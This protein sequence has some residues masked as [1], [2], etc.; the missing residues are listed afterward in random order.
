VEQRNAGVGFVPF[1]S[2][3]KLQERLACADIHVV[4]L[5]SDWTGMVVPSKFFGAL[6]AGRPVLFVGGADSSLARW[7]EEFEIG[8]VL[9][10]ENL[11]QVS[12]QLLSYMESTENIAA[13]HQRCFTVYQ[14]FFSRATQIQKFDRSLRSL[15]SL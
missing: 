8:W 4:T 14:Q 6:A 12:E 15:L 1:A 3:E 5:R 2:S 11:H 13:M 10:S 9:T 7:I